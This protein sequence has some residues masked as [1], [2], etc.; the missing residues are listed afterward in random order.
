[1]KTCESELDKLD[2]LEEAVSKGDLGLLLQAFAEN[3]DFGALLPSSVSPIA[4]I[5]ERR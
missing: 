2:D 3:V 4:T 5:L 1:V